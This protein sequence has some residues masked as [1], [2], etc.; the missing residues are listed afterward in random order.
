MYRLVDL[1][2]LLAAF[3]P[4]LCARA[5]ALR[6]LEVAIGVREHDRVAVAK[7]ISQARDVSDKPALIMCRTHIG[8]GSPS[9]QD[10]SKVHG[11]PLGVDEVSLTKEDRKWEDVSEAEER[12]LWESL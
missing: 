6:D 9:K 7:G 1:A 8:Y 11:E 5:A 3:R 10:T 2:G 12:T 4:V